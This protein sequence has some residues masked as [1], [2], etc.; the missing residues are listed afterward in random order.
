MRRLL[1]CEIY[2]RTSEEESIC[3]VKSRGIMSKRY[4][5][6]SHHPQ[7]GQGRMVVVTK[8]KEKEQSDG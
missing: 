4:L 2:T 6:C 5:L 7:A 3:E 8:A 1:R